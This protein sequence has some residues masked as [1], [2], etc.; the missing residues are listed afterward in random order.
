LAGTARIHAQDSNRLNAWALLPFSLPHIDYTMLRT[1]AFP[2]S[3]WITAEIL[4]V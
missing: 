2:S 1:C 3:R 4:A